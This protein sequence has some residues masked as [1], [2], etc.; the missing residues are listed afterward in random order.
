MIP[1]VAWMMLLIALSPNGHYVRYEGQTLLLVGDSGTQCIL[2]NPNIDYRLP[3]KPGEGVCRVF[4]LRE[5][6]HT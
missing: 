4:D 1:T 5:F 2:Q 6:L 3:G